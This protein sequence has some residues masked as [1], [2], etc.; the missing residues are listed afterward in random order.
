MSTRENDALLSEFHKFIFRSC[1]SALRF[2]GRHGKLTYRSSELSQTPRGVPG[3]LGLQ[4]AEATPVNQRPSMLRDG[5][6]VYYY[7]DISPLDMQ[8]ADDRRAAR[9]CMAHLA[10]LA[11]MQ[12][13]TPAQL[14]RAGGVCA[15]T[16]RRDVERLKQ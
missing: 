13:A 16:V 6:R 11:H 9:R 8:A 5:D 10:H 12:L 14:A 7:L 1:E 15:R 4:P 2:P 3:S